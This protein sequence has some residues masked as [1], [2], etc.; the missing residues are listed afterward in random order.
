MTGNNI[1][2]EKS[3]LA[4]GRAFELR[5]FADAPSSSDLKGQHIFSENFENKITE[6]ILRFDSH[7]SKRKTAGRVLL[8]AAIIALLI[9]FAMSF[10]AVRERAY[11]LFSLHTYRFTDYSFVPV[12]DENDSGGQGFL[13][14]SCELKVHYRLSAL[15]DGFTEKER[16]DSPLNCMTVYENEKNELIIFQ[17]CTITSEF[18][19]NSENAEC[20]EITADGITFYCTYAYGAS[21]LLW[22]QEGY[23]FLLDSSYPSEEAV[24]IA[25]SIRAKE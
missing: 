4:A 23:A 8:I 11:E 24:E 14:P 20:T 7:S 9:A 19:I 6:I 17:Q 21:T 22:E 12:Y 5:D 3:F 16:I 10:S 13:E 15:P 18:R 25:R 2:T 1:I